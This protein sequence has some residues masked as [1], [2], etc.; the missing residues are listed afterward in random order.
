MTMIK[1]V[2]KYR[3]KSSTRK[4]KCSQQFI[5]ME[6]ALCHNLI[7]GINFRCKTEAIIV[8]DRIYTSPREQLKK[9]PYL[10][11]PNFE[12]NHRNEG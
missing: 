10:N 7:V 11:A 12:Y 1:E 3:S 2:L 5:N 8:V 9:K 4:R 6:W